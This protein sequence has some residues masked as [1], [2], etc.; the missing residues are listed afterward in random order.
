MELLLVFATVILLV[1]LLQLWA[2]ASEKKNKQK[3]LYSKKLVA[4]PWA[5][6]ETK[7]LFQQFNQ[8]WSM[9]IERIVNVRIKKE[10]RSLKEDELR[11]R[12]YELKKFLFLAGISKGL[13]MFS[14]KIDVIWHFFLEEEKL[15][16]DFCLAFI[17]EQIEHHPHETPKDLPDERAWFDLLYLSFFNITS[18][19][20][21]WGKFVQRKKAHQN[22][23]ERLVN[24]PKAIVDLFG[25]QTSNEASLHALTA[26]VEFARKQIQQTSRKQ[27]KRK[28][29]ADG[30]WYGAIV[31]SSQSHNF[32]HENKKMKQDGAY[33][34]DYGGFADSFDQ[35]EQWNGIVTD[36]NTYEAGTSSSVSDSGGS[37]SGSSCSS[38]SGCSS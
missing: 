25:R 10:K 23:I 35:K 13:P 22:W 29:R 30:Y 7:Q 3:Y 5:D 36:V 9:E 26:F 38:C 12:W 14:Q 24:E 15:Y 18:R 20:H 4:P 11:E 6:K 19:S 1:V 27:V 34:G 21:R 37:D 17:G 28:K 16:R 2:H 31:F 32:V 33:A 8:A